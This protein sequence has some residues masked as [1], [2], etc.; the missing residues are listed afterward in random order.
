MTCARIVLRYYRV[1]VGRTINNRL[2][3]HAWR[4][5]TIR[6]RLADSR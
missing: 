3:I 6:N 5:R 2:H 4:I 1:H